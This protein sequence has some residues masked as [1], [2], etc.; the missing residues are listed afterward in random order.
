[1]RVKKKGGKEMK[2]KGKE[3]KEER[4][5]KDVFRFGSPSFFLPNF[6]YHWYSIMFQQYLR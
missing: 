4:R 2:G 3:E 1:M 6:Y 5:K